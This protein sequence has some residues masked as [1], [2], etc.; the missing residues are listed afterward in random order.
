MIGLST[1]GGCLRL[2]ENDG[3]EDGGGV[4]GET[5][6]GGP[7]TDGEN[8]G[9]NS[10]DEITGVE[11]APNW[12]KRVS[13][14][15]AADDDFFIRKGFTDL[16]RVRPDGREVFTSEFV[17][18]GM[19]MVGSGRS[20]TLAAGDSGIYV[21]AGAREE[22]AGARMYALDPETG[23]QQW[24]HREPTDGLHD[25]L[26]AGTKTDDLVLYASQSSGSGDDQEPIIRAL[27]PAD[28]EERWHIR[29]EG[30]F[31][32]GLAVA[33]DRLFVQETFGLYVYR[34]STQELLSEK[35]VSIGFS[36][37][38][39]DDDL[40]IVPGDTV[41]A[42]S[43]PSG[44]ER[45]SVETGRAVSTTPGVGAGGVFVGTESGYVLGFD[46]KS[47]EERWENR[48]DGV[49]EHPLIVADGLVW[50]ATERGDLA[51]F[52]AGTGEQAYA[53]EVAPDFQFT[54]QN[55]VL[56]DDERG[57]AYEIRRT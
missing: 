14:V 3:S 29:R 21:G 48:V 52:D 53:G 30:G 23:E 37:I 55:G 12:S 41:R 10:G 4:P 6:N 44:D 43:L 31:V 9:G 8:G 5:E 33:D 45:W 56:I 15:T 13:A 46:R 11:L 2:I 42:L 49:V 57:T 54:V 1:F 39:A 27:D 35:R 7:A 36:Q 32:N 40:L 25:G 16:L 28:G 26:R 18:D 22:G 19:L 50:V 34:L 20:N 17:D 47:G 24:S 51:A 38:V